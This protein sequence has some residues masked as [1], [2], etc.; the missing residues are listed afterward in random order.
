MCMKYLVIQIVG[1][2]TAGLRQLTLAEETICAMTRHLMKIVSFTCRINN[3]S[4]PVNN[5]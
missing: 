3:S 5:I 4:F 2:V 1:Q